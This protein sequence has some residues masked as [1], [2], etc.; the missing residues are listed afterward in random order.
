MSMFKNVFPNLS[1]LASYHP[2]SQVMV[3]ENMSRKDF[4]AAI[5]NPFDLNN[6]DNAALIA[7]ETSHFIDHI[8]TLYGQKMLLEIYNAFDAIIS[9]NEFLYW[10]AIKLK[11]TLHR[12]KYE[13]YYKEYNKD[14]IETDS[15][16][17]NWSFSNSIGLR[18]D[19]NG[20]ID[21]DR[22][23]IFNLFKFK[24]QFLARIPL[25]LEALWEA[26]AVASEIQIN[27]AAIRL[28]QNNDE[29][30]VSSRLMEKKYNDW[31][32]TPELLTYSTAT[33]IV[34][35]RLNLGD[36]FSASVATKAL[37]SISL[38]MPDKFYS[39]IKIPKS[40]SLPPNR[41]NGMM[42]SNDPSTLFY[43]MVV[44]V[45]ESGEGIFLDNKIEVDTEKILRINNLPSSKVMKDQVLIEMMALESQTLSGPFCDIFEHM[46]RNGQLIFDAIGIDSSNSSYGY[47]QIARDSLNLCG[48]EELLDEDNKI[49]KKLKDIDELEK[50]ISLFVHACGY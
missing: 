42:K 2:I 12:N 20:R 10:H 18:F 29:R 16:S 13:L 39:H 43:L 22:P 26:N 30:L 25:S 8:A 17:Y 36:I 46:R 27:T 7:H 35:S 15:K 11:D 32:Y 48:L 24:N 33:H 50:K 6:L 14:Y 28:I 3:F 38:N 45:Q 41:I 31:I 23:I 47:T 1:V 44:N 21:P 49:V 19:S 34:S 40:I 4:N 5:D 37:S 9:G